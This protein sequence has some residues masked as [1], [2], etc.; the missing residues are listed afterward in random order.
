MISILF[1]ILYLI[2]PAGGQAPLAAKF[3]L[4][5]ILGVCACPLMMVFIWMWPASV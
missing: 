2:A 4:F 5:I 3:L 1:Y